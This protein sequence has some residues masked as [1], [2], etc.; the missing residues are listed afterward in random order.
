MATDPDMMKNRDEKGTLR[1]YITKMFP[2]D[3]DRDMPDL[4][5]S[6]SDTWETSLSRRWIE[7][8]R[9]IE[10]MRKKRSELKH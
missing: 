3:L 6:G 7:R 1:L 2:R 4:L 8:Q 9:M 10:E 5:S